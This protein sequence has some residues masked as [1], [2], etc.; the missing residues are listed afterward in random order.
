[1]RLELTDHDLRPLV[2]AVVGEV[3]TNLEQRGMRDSEKLAYSEAEAAAMLGV[4]R[5]QLRDAR[6]RKEI[7]GSRAGKSVVYSRQ[8]LVQYLERTREEK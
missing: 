3:L 5:H 8:E 6:R 2:A 4:N 1:M 7:V